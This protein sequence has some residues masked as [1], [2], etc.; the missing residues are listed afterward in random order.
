V[1]T[2]LRVGKG[3]TER[4][5]MG[6]WEKTGDSSAMERR[7]EERTGGEHTMERERRGRDWKKIL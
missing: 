2:Y 1:F 4:E 7:V 6:E 5:E 3:G